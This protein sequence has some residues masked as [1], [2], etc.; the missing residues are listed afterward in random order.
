M[1]LLR[2]GLTSSPPASLP[3]QLPLPAS[4]YIRCRSLPV[5]MLSLSFNKRYSNS[6][7]QSKMQLPSSECVLLGSLA[8]NK[9]GK[10]GFVIYRCTYQ[11]D[12]AWER[13]KQIFHERTREYM[14]MSE[15]PEAATSL[16]EKLEWTFVEDRVALDGASRSQLRERFKEW[17]AQ[18]IVTE[19]PRARAKTER[20]PE[21]TFGIPRYQYFIQVD[22]EALQS[23]LAAPKDD[24]YEGGFINFVDSRWKPMGER[25]SRSCM[26]DNRD[27]EDGDEDE[28]IEDEDED[29]VFDTIDGCTEENVGWMRLAATTVVGT[30]FYVSVYDYVSGAWYVTYKRP[31][32][33]AIW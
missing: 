28:L 6:A 26:S 2:L 13:F 32:E 9:H 15:T 14:E 29:E 20:L 12:Y 10:W 8:A 16:A 31:P 22:E 1:G 25:P 17:A 3:L 21:P 30:E 23:V 7:P 5:R 19:Q 18:S 24:F 27:I 11:D 33:I 4:V